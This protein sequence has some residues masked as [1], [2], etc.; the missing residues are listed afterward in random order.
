MEND[1]K[2]PEIKVT[3]LAGLNLRAGRHALGQ[4]EADRV[5]GLY[6]AKNFLM[7]RIPGKALYRF[8]NGKKILG[9]RQTFD[10]SGN[11]IVQTDQDLQI[12]S[13]DEFLN[14]A[15]TFSLTPTG[16]TAE[17]AMSYALYLHEQS[18]GVDGGDLAAAGGDN[19]FAKSTINVEATDT[20]GIGTLASNEIT[21]A[22][23]IYRILAY[24]TF[25]A[26]QAL[27]TLHARAYLYNVTDAA[28]VTDLNSSTQIVGDSIVGFMSGGLSIGTNLTVLLSGR[29][30][31]TGSK[32]MAIYM[33]AD[34]NTGTWYNQG[35]AQGISSSGITDLTTS[36]V[37]KMI[38]IIKE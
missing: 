6:P 21:L 4:G 30:Q 16:G 5:F 36:E 24:I 32:A 29:F 37:Y 15:A 23:G 31:L 7:Q 27:G 17:E 20:A 9:L 10:G 12:I 33:A 34:A 28:V 35:T 25:G 8:L 14:R 11:V 22:A 26:A 38:E 1:A 3:R 13:L 19:V 18:N 2:T